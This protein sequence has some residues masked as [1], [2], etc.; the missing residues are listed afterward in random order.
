MIRPTTIKGPIAT[1]AKI[2]TSCRKECICMRNPLHAI[3]D[4]FRLGVILLGQA[5]DLI[6]VKNAISLHERDFTLLF[7]AVVLLFGFGDTVGIDNQ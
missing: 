6:D 1:M 7:G 3:D 4:G 5:F 2:G